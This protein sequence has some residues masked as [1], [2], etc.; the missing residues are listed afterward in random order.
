MRFAPLLIELLTEELPPKSLKKLGESFSQK[1][2]SHLKEL[3]L[4]ASEATFTFVCNT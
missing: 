3:N 1:I 4:L 2:F